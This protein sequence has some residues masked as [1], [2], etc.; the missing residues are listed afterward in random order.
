[1]GRSGGWQKHCSPGFFTCPRRPAHLDGPWASSGVVAASHSPGGAEGGQLGGEGSHTLLC[2]Q[3]IASR[4]T[5]ISINFGGQGTC[6]EV[7]S[8][9]ANSR[10]SWNPEKGT[11]KVTGGLRSELGLGLDPLPSS[12]GTSW[13][14]PSAGLPPRAQR[15]PRVFLFCGNPKREGGGAPFVGLDSC[16]G[17]GCAQSVDT[18]RRG[19]IQGGATGP[20]RLRASPGQ[21]GVTQTEHQ[22]A[23]SEGEGRGAGERPRWRPESRSEG[24]HR[25]EPQAGATGSLQPGPLSCLRHSAWT[26]AHQS[27]GNGCPLVFT[28]GQPSGLRFLSPPGLCSP[29]PWV[30]GDLGSDQ[31]IVGL[32]RWPASRP[33]APHL[34]GAP[35]QATQQGQGRL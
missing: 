16:P 19:L 2:P 35:M 31:V 25:G 5:F 23:R 10:R 20:R 22:G 27:T 34:A 33:E 13:L 7:P 6:G 14:D 28:A 3:Y 1:M 4:S 32:N 18:P 11:L 30:V 26:H 15:T 29:P 24:G 9:S 8:T 17:A 12:A 21:V